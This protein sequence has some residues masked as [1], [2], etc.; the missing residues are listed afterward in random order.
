L[1]VARAGHEKKAF[2]VTEFLSITHRRRIADRVAEITLTTEG[3]GEMVRISIVWSPT[4]PNI[5]GTV[6][7][8][9]LR[10]AVQA[11]GTDAVRLRAVLITEIEESIRRALAPYERGTEADDA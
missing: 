3:P 8:A 9:A 1:D 11:I 2:S 5:D 7:S 4:P 6:W 10:G